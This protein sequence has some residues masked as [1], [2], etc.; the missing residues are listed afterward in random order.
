MVMR[1][2]RAGTL[3]DKCETTTRDGLCCLEDYDL[4]W[5][6]LPPRMGGPNPPPDKGMAKCVADGNCVE[7]G[8]GWDWVPLESVQ[9]R[10][11]RLA[12]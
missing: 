11:A 1:S 6:R 2:K 10:P 3:G 9:A 12:H 7:R 5:A 8:D 4:T